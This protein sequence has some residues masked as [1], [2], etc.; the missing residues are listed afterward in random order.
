MVDKELHKVTEYRIPKLREQIEK[1]KD[2]VGS[3][4]VDCNEENWDSY[5]ASCITVQTI[6]YTCSVLDV[7][8]KWFEKNIGFLNNRAIRFDSCPCPNGEVH[9]EFTYNDSFECDILV[10]YPDKIFFSFHPK[11]RVRLDG[12]NT[13]ADR[14]FRLVFPDDNVSKN[15]CS[16]NDIPG[17]LD[18][19]FYKH[20][21]VFTDAESR[22]L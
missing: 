19:A 7:I 22:R 3:Y 12:I 15:R 8:K 5:N 4:I 6:K 21:W 11:E 1:A 18:E 2:R 10:R 16:K 14:N 17:L 13:I 20:K 9:I